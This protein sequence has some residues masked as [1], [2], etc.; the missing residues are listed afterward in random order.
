MLAK[1]QRDATHPPRL[2]QHLPLF[3]S[4][5]FSL[6]YCLRVKVL[7]CGW[8]IPG[9]VIE[10]TVLEPATALCILA[11]KMAAKK[12]EL[13]S[14]SLNPYIYIYIILILYNSS[15]HFCDSCK[16]CVRSLRDV[17]KQDRVWNSY[18]NQYNTVCK[19]NGLIPKPHTANSMTKYDKVLNVLTKKTFGTKCPAIFLPTSFRDFQ[20]RYS[21]TL[22]FLRES[23]GDSEP[24]VQLRAAAFRWFLG[25]ASWRRSDQRWRS[26]KFTVEGK[27]V[28]YLGKMIQY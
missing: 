16:H 25:S 23:G 15:E 17:P 21:K 8:I 14:N 26:K 2:P 5:L 4:F 24:W 20:G 13:S 19:A 7:A 6:C 18:S 11:H 9:E 10:I 3:L 28:L 12:R 1:M 22:Q 27:H